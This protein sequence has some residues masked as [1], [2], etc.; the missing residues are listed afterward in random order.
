M[1]PSSEPD[2]GDNVDSRVVGIDHAY[3]YDPS[4]S[5][6]MNLPPRVAVAAG[7]LALIPVATFGL[8]RAGIHVAI[9]SGLSVI[10][11]VTALMIAFGP[12]DPHHS[13]HDAEG[14]DPIDRPG[15]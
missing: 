13:D 5:G 14:P 1:L 3:I 15:G 2:Q 6:I 12:T 8:F 10:I 4:I 7:L 11:V 9:I